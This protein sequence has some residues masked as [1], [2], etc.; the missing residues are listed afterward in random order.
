MR[1]NLAG[2]LARLEA[3]VALPSGAVW[4]HVSADDGRTSVRHWRGATHIFVGRDALEA[5]PLPPGLHLYGIER[6][7]PYPDPADGPDVGSGPG[8]APT[9][10][11]LAAFAAELEADPPLS[12]EL[13][14]EVFDL[15]ARALPGRAGELV[16]RATAMVLF[17]H[18]P[19]APEEGEPCLK[20]A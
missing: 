17:D 4:V 16:A 19:A 8:G 10:R 5:W 7:R 20:P 12:P 1:L 13:V 3:R 6:G 18:R 14:A 11:E 9:E 15:V 2:R